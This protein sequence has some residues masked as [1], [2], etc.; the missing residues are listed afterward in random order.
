M[1]MNLLNRSDHQRDD[2]NHLVV[3][4]DLR[5]VW[6]ATWVVIGAVSLVTAL[7][8]VSHSAGSAIFTILMAFFLAFAIEPAVKRL[9]R[10][11][12]RGLATTLVIVTLTLAV[13]GFLASFGTLL[14]D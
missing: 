3:S 13:V 4:L 6:H 1:R 12:R 7:G 10:F 5:S 11:M 9:E 8:F 14:V 2:A